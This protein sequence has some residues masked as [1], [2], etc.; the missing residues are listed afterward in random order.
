MIC[1]A[2]E[3]CARDAVVGIVSE[4]EFASGEVE[5][6]MLM[7]TPA[8]EVHAGEE[9]HEAR[10]SMSPD[11]FTVLNILHAAGDPGRLT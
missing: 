8:C 2:Q 6:S 1:R 9:V 5:V 4:F 10:A 7:M 3:E 11:E